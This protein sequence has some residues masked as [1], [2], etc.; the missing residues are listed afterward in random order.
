L[1]LLGLH[2]EK[3]SADRRK[4]N[5]GSIPP[6]NPKLKHYTLGGT[7]S[8]FLVSA[9]TVRRWVRDG[10]LEPRLQLRSGRCY[11][12]LFSEEE[13]LRFCDE[14]LPTAADLELKPIK[15]EKMATLKRIVGLHRAYAGKAAAAKV[16]RELKIKA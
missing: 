1:V 4:I 14:F 12:L 9:N 11:R 13:L 3:K 6:M 7:A 10:L 8:I 5:T 16:A 2:A 15:N